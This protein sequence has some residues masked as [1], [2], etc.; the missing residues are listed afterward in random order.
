MHAAVARRP[1]FLAAVSTQTADGLLLASHPQS[2]FSHNQSSWLTDGT[3]DVPYPLTETDDV[4]DKI[5]LPKFL[6][7]EDFLTCFP[8][9]SL[10]FTSFIRHTIETTFC[11][12]LFLSYSSVLWYARWVQVLWRNMSLTLSGTISHMTQYPRLGGT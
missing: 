10:T 6:K 5:L 4:T 2:M 11:V 9:R 8:V 3:R 7:Y 12:V 1:T